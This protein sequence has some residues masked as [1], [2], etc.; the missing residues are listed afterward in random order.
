MMLG[1]S[2]LSRQDTTLWKARYLAA[3][4]PLDARLGSRPWVHRALQLRVAEMRQDRALVAR[5]V[6][7]RHYLGRWPCP[8]RT[9]ILSYLADLAGVRQVGG[10]GAAACAMVAL[11]PGQ[12]HAARALDVH[13]C[14]VLQLVRNWRADDLGP[15]VTPDL[16]PEVLRRIVRGDR[17]RGPLRPLAEEWS[18]RKLRAGG[19][20]AV[21][22]LLVSYADPAVGHDG[23]LYRGAGATYCGPGAQG[24]LL[25]AWA[26]DLALREPLRA[27][28]Q[29]VEERGR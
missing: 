20:W 13:P 29:A 26:L 15:A 4:L 18:A 12:I 25:W 19:L 27:L 24:R 3:Q 2:D 6:R 23:G 17:R 8:P 22:R 11:L 7:G 5:I 1:A 21:P 10:A 16:M 28:G 9:L 14:S